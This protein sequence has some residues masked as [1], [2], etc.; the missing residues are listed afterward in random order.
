MIL[1]LF[2]RIKSA[3]VKDPDPKVRAK[4]VQDLAQEGIDLVAAQG[5]AAVLRAAK[6]AALLRA[7][8]IKAAEMALDGKTA[9][10]AVLEIIDEL[11]PRGGES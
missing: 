2:N 9:E 8:E 7:L 11:E 5:E 10:D 3:A 6:S 4:M 1:D